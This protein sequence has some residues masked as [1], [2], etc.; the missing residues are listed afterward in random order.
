MERGSGDI[1]RASYQGAEQEHKTCSLQETQKM[2]SALRM[3]AAEGVQEAGSGHPGLPLGMADVAAVLWGCFLNI[4]PQ[5]PDWPDRDRFILSAG[6]GSILL[7]ALLHLSGFDVS[8]RDLRQFRTL[9]SI[10]PGHPEYG[11]TP[12]VETTTGPLAQGFGNGVGMALAENLLR[13]HF[14]EESVNHWTYVLCSDGCLMEG[15][16][17]E[18]L[19]FAGHHHLGRLIVLFDDNGIT[20]DG[21]TTLVTSEDHQKRFEAAGWHVEC[22]D[23]HDHGAI[24]K[25]LEAAQKETKRPTLLMCRTTIGYGAGDKAG[26]AAVHGA[27]LGEAAVAALRANSGF[28]DCEPFQLPEEIYT[29]WKKAMARGKEAHAHWQQRQKRDPLCAEKLAKRLQNQLPENWEDQFQQMLCQQ[30]WL[31]ESLATRA[32][33]G[34]VL[35]VLSTIVPSLLGGSAD[36]G[37]SNNTYV[38]GAPVVTPGKKTD[39]SKAAYIHYGVREH[40]MAAIMN[41]LALHKGFMPYGGTFLVF[42]DYMRP[43]MRLAALMGLPVV[44]VL[45]HDSIGVGEDG[46]THQPVEHAWSL[47]A[48]PGLQVFRPADGIEVAE[49]WQLAL[50]TRDKPSALLLS[51][52]KVQPVRQKMNC[53][54][55]SARGAYLLQEAQAALQVTLWATGSEVCLAQEIQQNLE[56]RSIGTRVISA[57]CLSLFDQ[58][59][60][61]YKASLQTNN[62]HVS[63]EAGATL[64]WHRYT[65]N[66][67]LCCGIDNFG[68]SGAAQAVYAQKQLTAEKVVEAIER[69]L[70]DH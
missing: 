53:D 29:L 51:R 1:L 16:A 10:T 19:S 66:Q 47:R 52:Q 63:L 54:K 59:A 7:Y 48:I 35:G 5:K 3:L 70:H 50:R 4:D 12:G 56:K 2:A 28:G 24:F 62:L 22:V 49:C 9:H 33:S 46:P 25:A 30:P 6:H 41:G 43:A 39:L 32:Y 57:P 60:A 68:L 21:A 55:A 65:G 34:K 38:P 67:G 26:T 64:G 37:G 17:A 69:V 8:A 61:A 42:S 15:L 44:Y 40:G 36:L 27:P 11:H 13:K 23:G 14:G 31:K 45:T 58:Q 18:A 20:I